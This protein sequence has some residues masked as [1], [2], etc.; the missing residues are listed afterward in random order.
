MRNIAVI[1]AGGAGRSLI[2]LLR[3]LAPLSDDTC[4]FEET[5]F[6]RAREVDGVHVRD[7]STFD[8]ERW[9]LFVALGTPGER[10]RIVSGLPPETVFARCVHP[11]AFVLE[12][13]EIPPGSVLYPQVYLSRNVRLG[14]HALLM[15]GTVIGHDTSLGDFF[16]SSTHVAI[17]GHAQ[18]GQRVFCGMHSAVRDRVQ[19][20]HD[21]T[22]GMGAMA[23]SDLTEP[24]VYIGSP[25]RLK[26]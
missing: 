22:L 12:N 1:G 4:F 9:Q 14:A 6:Y 21:C 24:G 15:P 26:P 7:L 19:V 11:L 5:E 16:T 25:A 13:T 3:N 20:G 17:G 10:A 18:I 8:P 23:V 2:A